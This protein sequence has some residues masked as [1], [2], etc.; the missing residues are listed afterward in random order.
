MARE[1]GNLVTL[2]IYYKDL[3]LIN[4]NLNPMAAMDLKG[5]HVPLTSEL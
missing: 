5:Y 2:G 3:C 1:N 4:D